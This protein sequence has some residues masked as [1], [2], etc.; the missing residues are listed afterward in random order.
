MRFAV[1]GILICALAVCAPAQCPVQLRQASV[2][3]NGKILR[4]R[5]F[6][7]GSRP[8]RAVQFAL[9]ETNPADQN[10]EFLATYSAGIAVH[11]SQEVTVTFRIHNQGSDSVDVGSSES[12]S[13]V[14]RRIQF[15][16]ASIWTAPQENQCRISISRH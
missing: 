13:L 2:D 10:H 9:T 1:L 15:I 3:A 4:V 14:V 5:Y 7:Q 11:P 6:N 8:I 16:G 12:A